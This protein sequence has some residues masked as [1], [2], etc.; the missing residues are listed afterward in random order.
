MTD[1][2]N[3]GETVRHEKPSTFVVRYMFYDTLKETKTK[4]I[5]KC[6]RPTD[7][8]IEGP[9]KLGAESRVHP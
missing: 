5:E 4:I 2:L 3:D 9:I 7:R 1:L 6:D 8:R